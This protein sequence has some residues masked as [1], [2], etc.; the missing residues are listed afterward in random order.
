M[1]RISLHDRLVKAAMDILNEHRV[2]VIHDGKRYLGTVYRGATGCTPPQYYFTWNSG[3]SG[4]LGRL[5][6]KLSNIEGLRPRRDG[7]TII[8]VV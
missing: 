6:F 3:E 7:L 2:E 4:V 1:N 8:E 5:E